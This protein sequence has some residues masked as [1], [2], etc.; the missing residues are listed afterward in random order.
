[1]SFISFGVDD[2]L[3]VGAGIQSHPDQ[4]ITFNAICLS[5]DVC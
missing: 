4:P 2:P 5:A 1:M 3:L